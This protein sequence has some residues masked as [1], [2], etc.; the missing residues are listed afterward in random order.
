MF[1]SGKVGV[2]PCHQEF[3]LLGRSWDVLT[4]SGQLS[5]TE[6]GAGLKRF[7]SF[8]VLKEFCS[9]SVPKEFYCSSVLQKFCCSSFLKEFCSSSVLKEF[10]LFKR[11]FAA[12]NPPLLLAPSLGPGDFHVFGGRSSHGMIF[13]LPSNPKSDFYGGDV[14]GDEEFCSV[15]AAQHRER[16][17]LESPCAEG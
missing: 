4:A 3:L 5:S 11:N 17:G 15:S 16:A 6:D 10:L 9:S 2:G 1:F 8:S 13:K 7:Y 14:V 12:A